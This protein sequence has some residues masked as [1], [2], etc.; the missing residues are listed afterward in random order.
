MDNLF[1]NVRSEVTYEVEVEKDIKVKMRDDI[2][3]STDIYYP[4]IDGKID[5]FLTN[6]KYD[7][8]TENNT[9]L[10]KNYCKYRP[11]KNSL[12]IGIKYFNMYL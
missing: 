6:E 10:Y 11:N 4:T 9:Q 12:K 1:K 3:L 8:N 5:K 2:N 7:I